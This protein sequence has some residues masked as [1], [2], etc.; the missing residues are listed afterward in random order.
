[1]TAH[2]A[3]QHWLNN[4]IETKTKW[5]HLIKFDLERDFAAGVY[6]SEAQNLISP[7]YALDTCIH[8]GKGGGVRVEPERR[9]E[10]Q[11]FTKLGRKYQHDL[12]YLQ[13]INFDK[14]LPQSPITGQF[15]L[16]WHFAFPSMSLIFLRCS[17][18]TLFTSDDFSLSN[19][20]INRLLNLKWNRIEKKIF[21][22]PPRYKVQ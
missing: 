19:L 20:S 4:Y 22:Y 11:Q 7:P 13:S 1:M 2:V 16:G 21:I 3:V 10:G 12:L 17:V 15:Y 5:R 14:H 6:L 18:F 8:K 9:R